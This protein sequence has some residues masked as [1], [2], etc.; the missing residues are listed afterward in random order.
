MSQSLL[1]KDVKS[2]LSFG[3]KLWGDSAAFN[4][5]RWEDD[6]VKIHSGLCAGLV[7]AAPSALV[8][9]CRLWMDVFGADANAD[10][11]GEESAEGW[12]G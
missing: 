5:G 10:E 9:T 6:F 4:Q 8:W 7:W 1:L 12:V 11:A 2:G 3:G